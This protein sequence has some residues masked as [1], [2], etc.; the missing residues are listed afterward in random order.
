MS[1]KTVSKDHYGPPLGSNKAQTSINTGKS[2]HDASSLLLRPQVPH[3]P[4]VADV[5]KNPN[6]STSTNR[7]TSLQYTNILIG[8]K[9]FTANTSKLATLHNPSTI[10]PQTTPATIEN[11][12]NKLE[13]L[14]IITLEK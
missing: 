7:Y 12:I 8:P 4:T 6:P 11:Y 10:N 3:K 13:T 14:P 5:V 9:D 1:G 2:H